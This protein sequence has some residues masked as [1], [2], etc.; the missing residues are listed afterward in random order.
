MP[1]VPRGS[2]FRVLGDA[3]ADSGQQFLNFCRVLKMAINRNL[4]VT[5]KPKMMPTWHT[6]QTAESR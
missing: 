6:A 4:R 5:E 2:R 3:T 1:I